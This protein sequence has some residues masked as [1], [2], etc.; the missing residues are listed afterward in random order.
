[1]RVHEK[2][3]EYRRKLG[4]KTVLKAAGK[5][6]ISLDITTFQVGSQNVK[7]CYFISLQQRK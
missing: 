1:M 6:Q 7:K 5:T 4:E 3:N 2:I